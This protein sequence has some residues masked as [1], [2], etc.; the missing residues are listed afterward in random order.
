MIN[1]GVYYAEDEFPEGQKPIM[2]KNNKKFEAYI[3]LLTYPKKT[4][5]MGVSIGKAG[6]GKTLAINKFIEENTQNDIQSLPTIA[7]FKVPTTA[8]A[9]TV[10]QE[11]CR[12]LDEIPSKSGNKHDIANEAVDYIER[13]GI[14]LIFVDEADRLNA[15]SFDIIR[16]M[17]DRTGCVFVI[18]GLPQ[19]LQVIDGHE[20]FASRIGPRMEFTKPD[21]EEVL[22]TILPQLTVLNWQYD[23]TSIEDRNLGELAWKMSRSFRRLRTLLESAGILADLQKETCITEV[24]LRDAF[25]LLGSK[26]DKQNIQKPPQEPPSDTKLEDE[27]ERRQDAKNDDDDDDDES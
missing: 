24:I 13:N 19:I 18:V 4:S 21:L 6:V 20:Q 1:T 14:K 12:A 2:T 7:K 11:L 9:R 16:Y 8:T 27:S 26:D 5:K 3:T 15:E 23:V 22:D 17:F 25:E 10:A